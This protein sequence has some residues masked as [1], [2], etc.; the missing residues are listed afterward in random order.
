VELKSIVILFVEKVLVI[1]NEKV[2][3]YVAILIVLNE[4]IVAF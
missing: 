1:R 3:Y 2:F 4:N